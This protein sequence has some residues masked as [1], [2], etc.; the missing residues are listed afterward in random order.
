MEEKHEF[1]L[2]D[3]K[4][5]S[6]STNITGD[7]REHFTSVDACQEANITIS[8][9][10]LNSSHYPK[11]ERTARRERGR[12]NNQLLQ[13]GYLSNAIMPL[14]MRRNLLRIISRARF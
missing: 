6:Y 9:F 5:F 8:M 12:N 3:Y 2:T 7:Q 4:F 10:A 14:T 13:H 11:K 1:A